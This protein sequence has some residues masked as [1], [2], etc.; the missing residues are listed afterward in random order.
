MTEDIKKAV[1]SGK[2]TSSAGTALAKLPPG[3]FVQHKSWGYGV[4]VSH[5]FLMSQTTIDFKSKKGH[6]MQLQYAGESLTALPPD[7]IAAK[8]YQDL[9]AVRKLGQ[10]EPAS[11]VRLVLQSLGGRASQEQ[12]GSQLVPDVFNEAAFKKWWEAAKR[13][14]KS[15]PLVGVPQKKTDPFILREQG[16]SQTDEVLA[17]FK[18][19]RTLKDQITALDNLTKAL[20][21]F[22][23]PS[24]LQPVV[25]AIENAAKKNVK[26]H[27]GETLQ[28]LAVRDEI[29]SKLPALATS[30]DTPTISAILRE[31]D[32]QLAT[33]L[34]ELPVSKLKKVILALPE[35]FSD[36]WSTKAIS[37]FIRGNSKLAPEAARLLIEKGRMDEFGVALDKAIRD[38]TISSEGLQWL[39]E[40]RHGV[41]GE[42]AQHPRVLSAILGAMERD[43]FKE[44]RDRKLQDMLVNDQELLLDLVAVATD[45][46]LRDVM[47]KLVLSPTFEEL[48]KRS[49]LGRIVRTY[50]ELEALITGRP[51][52]DKKNEL[53]VSWKSLEVRKAEYDDLVNKKIP[54]NRQDI[55]IARSYGDLRENFEYKS[56]KEQ[57]RV[58]SRQKSEA[59]R[60]L[61][62]SRGTD[63]AGVTNEKV[64]I[65][66][67][68]KLRRVSDGGEESYTILGAW[69]T[70]PAK[71]IIS[72]L[73][74]MAQALIGHAVGERVTVP[75]ETGEH[76]VEIL[77][78][79]VAQV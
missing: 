52:D 50:P 60:D 30:S 31:Q 8:K 36:H 4:I 65:G 5:D 21:Q 39:C 13:A 73:S 71:H 56:A 48:N 44:K 34:G 66:T 54:Q 10:S 79:A 16:L 2:L 69:D 25:A 38:Q 64:A 78:I 61:A 15:D 68:V 51:D 41:Y 40:E 35:A 58:L 29:V 72:Y 19:A 45:E 12:I 59:E 37:L 49:L 70:D 55:Q 74:Q 33:L 26:L 77:S 24:V 17:A 67:S 57:Q 9:D 46:E 27:T 14:L 23:D 53:I 20:G 7:H 43:Q 18:A 6:S 3:T 76:E 11:L 75:K 62:R 22:T 28:L 1:E 32:R 63:F 42:I 47:R